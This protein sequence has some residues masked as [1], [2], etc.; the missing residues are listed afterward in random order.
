MWKVY[1]LEFVVVV[2][3]SILWVRGIVDMH[4]KHPDYKGEEL[5]G[6]DKEEEK[7]N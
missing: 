2:I 1:L 5:F 7:K 3:V 4:E 6:E